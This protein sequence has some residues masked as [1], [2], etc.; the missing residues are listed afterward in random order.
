[1]LKLLAVVLLALGLLHLQC[2]DSW[3]LWPVRY[4]LKVEN[5][6]KAT[7]DVHCQCE[8]YPELGLQHIPPQGH[9]NWTFKSQ[10]FKKIVYNCNFTWPNHAH[11]SFLVFED[12]LNF[13]DHLCGGRHCTWRAA[14]DGI[15]LYRLYKQK[16]IK[17][18]DW[19]N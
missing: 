18:E 6:L 12:N 11:K 16:Y 10:F 14:E 7:L 9:F 8:D 2:A 5:A 1:M 15:Y 13:V 3:S 17:M 4:W 19:D